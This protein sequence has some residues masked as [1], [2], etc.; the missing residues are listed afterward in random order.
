M[1]AMETDKKSSN[2]SFLWTLLLVVVVSAA[3][4]VM[5]WK[6]VKGGNHPRPPKEGE[7]LERPAPSSKSADPDGPGFIIG[8]DEPAKP[9]DPSQFM[10]WETGFRPE[11]PGYGA[12]PPF[13]F[14]DHTGAPFA[15]SRLDG[16]VWIAD[17]IFTRCQGPCPKMTS[18]MESIR[19]DLKDVAGIEFVSFSVDPAYDTP[20]VLESYAS[21]YGGAGEGWHLLTGD[22]PA[23]FKLSVKTFKVTAQLEDPNDPSNVAHSTRFFLIGRDGVI[24]GRY[25]SEEKAQMQQLRADARALAAKT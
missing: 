25:S 6:V 22:Q 11:G 12:V 20:Q 19:K 4:G 10:G 17:F 9:A 15:K 7:P 16:K 2:Q 23:I 3:V 21:H 13:E 18:E 8:K 24:R 1:S 5:F 14:T